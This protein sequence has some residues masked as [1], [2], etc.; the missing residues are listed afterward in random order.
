VSSFFD[1]STTAYW[2]VAVPHLSVKT[3]GSGLKLDILGMSSDGGTYRVRV[4][5]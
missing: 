1:S 3:A 4:H 5:K 2:N